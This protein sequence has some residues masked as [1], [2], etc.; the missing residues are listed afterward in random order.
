[1]KLGRDDLGVVDD[2]RVAG[3]Q[4]IRQIADMTVLE[5]LSGHHHQHARGVARP[6]RAKR[7]PVFRKVEI[8]K[9]NTHGYTKK[10]GGR[11]RP[12][13]FLN[14]SVLGNN[15]A[16]AATFIETI[17]SGSLTGSPRLILS[18][19]S[20]PSVTLPQTVY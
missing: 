5:S 10:R 12:P 2:E 8:E 18:M 13:R 16:S 7:D 9:I 17:L 1:V 14:V 6:R 20:I 3:P 15:Q 11:W 19:F 4:H